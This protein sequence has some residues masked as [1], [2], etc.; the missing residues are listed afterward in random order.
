MTLPEHP[1]VLVVE[2]EPAPLKVIEASLTARHFQVMTAT[3]GGRA[4][5][6]VAEKPPDAMVVDLGL[7]DMDGLVLC[8][9]LRLWT[10]SPIIVVTADGSEER[11]VQA[12]DEGA[13]DYVT[14]PFS[15]PELLARI[16]VAIRHRATLSSVYDESTI[17]VGALSLDI[18]AREARL[19][20]RL[21]DLQPKQFRLLILLARNSGRVLTY[22]QVAQ[23]LWGQ[24]DQK[25]VAHEMRL[26]VST[27]RR[28]LGEG[29]GVPH[30]T[31]EPRIGYRL[32]GPERL[33]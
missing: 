2:D 33:D 3:T 32:L 8:R 6:L 30:I 29:E 7:P 12:L 5:E 15:M 22:R 1:V 26:L 20:G 17:V 9:H 16:R 21:I 14:K 23:Q 24:E 11:M 27:L 28:K 25:S 31:A 19:S 13:D 4:L 10:K 18:A